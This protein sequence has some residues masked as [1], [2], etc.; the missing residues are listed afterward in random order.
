[1]THNVPAVGEVLGARIG[2]RK[3]VK[4]NSYPAFA[5]AGCQNLGEG[6]VGMAKP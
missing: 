1:M 6:G 2:K 5:F 4:P 3:S